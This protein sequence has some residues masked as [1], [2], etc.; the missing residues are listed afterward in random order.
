MKIDWNEDKNIWLKIN[1]DISFEDVLVAIE[2]GNLLAVIEH[3]NKKKYLNQ[4]MFVVNIDN[5]TFCVPFVEDKEKIFL[6][7]IFPNRK[8]LKLLVNKNKYEQTKEK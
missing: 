6:K 1:R 7:T 8:F 5:Y 3:P 2:S 4:K